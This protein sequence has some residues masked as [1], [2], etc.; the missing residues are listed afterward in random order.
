[1]SEKPRG[2]GLDGPVGP[3][4]PETGKRKP[5]TTKH[6]RK[7]PHRQPKVSDEVLDGMPDTADLGTG[8]E[9]PKELPNAFDLRTYLPGGDNDRVKINRA[10]AMVGV[11]ASVAGGAS[12]NQEAAA[13]SGVSVSTLRDWI[14]RGDAGDS[15]VH[16]MFLKQYMWAQANSKARYVR[17]LDEAGS[18]GDT[19]ANIH[20]L[21]RLDRRDLRATVIDDGYS[22][23][24]RDEFFA[25]MAEHP[26]VLKRVRGQLPDETEE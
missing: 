18:L 25:A 14:R 23:M 2:F 9:S 4:D 11:I 22:G 8:W 3:V 1:M 10:A 21:E 16:A 12:T 6:T 26:E 24:T 15:P 20:L 19:K 13:L 5:R 17:R 7:S